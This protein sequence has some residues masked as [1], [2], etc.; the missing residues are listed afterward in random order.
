MLNIINS[1]LTKID[2]IAQCQIECFP[3]SFNSKLGQVFVGKTLTW[4]LKDNNKFLYHIEENGKVV[5]F[6][7]GFVPQFYGDGSSSGMLQQG[8]KEAVIGVL[9]RPWLFFNK[10]MIA[11]YPFIIRNIKK[12]L[13]LR[14]TTAAAPKPENFEFKKGAGLVVIGVHPAFRGKGV[15]EQLM[16]EFERKSS[17]RNLTECFLS[18]RS[19]NARAIAAY[20][21]MGWF[22]YKEEPTALYMK[23][24][25]A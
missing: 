5:G 6:C 2:V 12:K 25:I 11:Y 8:F 13:G 17:E 20:K 4:F 18:V 1:T 9:K 3:N 22:V 14:K 7:G 15:F 21:K 24:V 16:I 10:E 23:K 19:D